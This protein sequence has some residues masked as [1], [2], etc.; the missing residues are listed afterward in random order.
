MK[1][2]IRVPNWIGDAFFSTAFL[3]AVQ[4][5]YP[6]DEIFLIGREKVKDVFT[7]F[8]FKKFIEIKDK[9]EGLIKTGKKLQKYKFD[10]F[11]VLPDSFSAALLA[12][13]SKAKIR[14]GF[15]S[16]F[17]SIFLTHRY[18]L[19][20]V[21]VHRYKKYLLLLKNFAGKDFTDKVLP[22]LKITDNEKNFGR[23][24]FKYLRIN[25]PFIGINPN[26]SAWSRRWLPERFAQLA[27]YIA[28]RYKTKV[29]FFGSKSESDF[30]TEIIKKTKFLHYNVAGMI[31]LREYIG[32]LSHLHL[33]I[34][35]DSGPMHLANAAGATVIALEGP[36]NIYETGMIGKGEKYYIYKKLPCIFCRKNYCK[37]NH[38]CMKL[39]SVEDVIKYVKQELIKYEKKN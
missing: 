15:K 38:E 34:T 18:R 32:I 20:P 3:K 36:A 39:I 33:F 26:V 4:K 2:G 17:R 35:N 23:Y 28:Q 12:Y 29:L 9:K 13:F 22:E 25:P 11:F 6:Q 10:I 16:E 24:F 7:N 8:K 5:L 37:F 27:D 14:A 19:P 21:D 30:V 31:S 1:I